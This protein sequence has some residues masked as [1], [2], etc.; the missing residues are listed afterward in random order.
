[1]LTLE[2]MK[3]LTTGITAIMVMYYI[4]SWTLWY[5]GRHHLLLQSIASGLRKHNL[6]TALL[7]VHSLISVG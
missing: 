7:S 6:A 3:Q 4:Q 1:M 2:L 5:I